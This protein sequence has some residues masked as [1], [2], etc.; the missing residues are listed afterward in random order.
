MATTTPDPLRA[1]ASVNPLIYE[2][3]GLRTLMLRDAVTAYGLP[4]DFAILIAVLAGLVTVA[5]RR[6]PR[7]AI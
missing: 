2:V 4:L 6:Y 1:V 7:M 5:A 3:D